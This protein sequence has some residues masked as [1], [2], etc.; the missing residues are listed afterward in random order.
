MPAF[1]PAFADPLHPVLALSAREQAARIKDGSLTSGE[2]VELYLARIERHNPAVG[3]FVSTFADTARKDADKADA[4][5][6]NDRSFGTFHGVPT[7]MK[8][9]HFVKRG[10]TRMGSRSWKYLWSPIDDQATK[11]IRKGGF[12]VVGKTS[13]SELGLLPIVETDIHPPTRNPWNPAH[14]AGGSSGGAGAA[15]AAGLIPIAPGSDG[16][17]SVRIPASLA[18][19]V[20][21]KPSRGLIPM[22]FARVDLH[23][24]ASVGPLARDVEDAAALLDVLAGT[25]NTFL[26]ASRRPVQPLRLGLVVDPP[27]GDVHPGIAA[28]VRDAARAAEA[29]GHEVVELPPVSVELDEF[30]PIYQAFVARIPVP[31]E[32]QLQPMTRWFRAQGRALPEGMAKAQFDKLVAR[33]LALLEGVD[34]LITPTIPVLPPKVGEFAHL[35]PD[36]MFRALSPLGAFTAAWNITGLPALTVPWG[37]VDGFPVGVQLVGKMGFDGQLLALGRTLQEVAA[38]R[39]VTSS[40][41]VSVKA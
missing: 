12:I 39:V 41:P 28:R 18:G 1:A 13:T 20:G 27:M 25:G 2:L 26:E 16:A 5:R 19:L 22:A 6:K 4:A 23:Q 7:A 15:V 9:L 32:S 33:S 35:A 37:Q 17:G 8:D 3:A 40:F 24:M 29:L 14:T 11:S 38:E 34:G 36:A 30:L 21:L 31:F 10:F